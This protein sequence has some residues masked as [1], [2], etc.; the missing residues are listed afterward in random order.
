VERYENQSSSTKSLPSG[1]VA[2]VEPE[3]RAERRSACD[4]VIMPCGTMASGKFRKARMVD[5]SES[6]IALLATRRLPP[7]EQF[8]LKIRLKRIVLAVYTVRHCRPIDDDVYR[9]GAELTGFIG[10]HD[11]DS[12]AIFKALLAT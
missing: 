3:R 12:A 6:G 4:V 7:G 11:C 1:L 8:M 5:C 2:V 10:P 9:I